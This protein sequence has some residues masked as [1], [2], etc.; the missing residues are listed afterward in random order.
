MIRLKPLLETQ[1]I[2]EALPYNMAKKYV[3]IERNPAIEARLSDILSKLAEQEGAKSS[4]RRDRVAI[5]FDHKFD[6]E[7]ELQQRTSNK[8][9]DFSNNLIDF[10]RDVNR[11]IKNQSDDNVKQ[12]PTLDG[13]EQVVLGQL[14]DQY[15]RAVKMSKYIKMLLAYKV[16]LK[17]DRISSISRI[18]P[19][20][21]ERG[22]TKEPD[23]QWTTL[24]TIKQAIKKDAQT[25][26]DKL[27]QEYD[28]IPEVKHYRQNKDKSY[29]LVFSKHSYDIAGMSTDR[30]WTSCMN[31]YGGMNNKYIQYD[32]QEGTLVVYLVSEDD[33]N[34]TN[35]SARISIKPFVNSN[36]SN[37]VYYQPEN[38]VYGTAPA[39]FEETVNNLIDSV[40][41]GKEGLFRLI[42][43]LYCDSTTQVVK[44]SD[45]DIAKKVNELISNKQQ[46]TTVDEAKYLLWKYY[47]FEFDLLEHFHYE[48][49]DKLYVSSVVN[50][51]H[52]PSKTGYS[53]VQI[54]KC[55]RFRITGPLEPDSYKTFPIEADMV[56][57]TDPL[58]GNFKGM[59]TLIHKNLSLEAYQTAAHITNF[60]GLQPGLS[61]VAIDF[62][63]D[64]ASSKIDSFHGI[65]AT[66]SHLI[67]FGSK[68]VNLNMTIDEL[69][70]QLKP[71]GLRNFRGLQL[72]NVLNKGLTTAPQSKL[73]NSI[74]KKLE[75]IPGHNPKIMNYD[76]PDPSSHVTSLNK[77]FRFLA[78][79]FSELPTLER[80]ELMDSMAWDRDDLSNEHY[81]PENWNK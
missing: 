37:D 58:Q 33:L 14:P 76:A 35:P 80:V 46:A 51:F 68:D 74:N 17:F 24:D 3:S 40:Q 53:P 29:Y 26:F 44:F 41:P 20:T 12:F 72:I 2:R 10:R 78:W 66:V 55:G 36:D 45:P 54:G 79:F 8:L 52:V 16:K 28:A 47:R 71:I 42:D 75:D 30:G 21:G 39:A 11:F 18:N 65:P 25:K 60:E 57:I 34:I 77:Q 13:P 64:S 63:S 15:G 6:I 56:G 9:I 19:D 31:L 49:S 69:I 27:M 62:R 73:F 67:I 81:Q 32:I 50:N 7:F 4:R 59:N 70:S 22:V 1:L 38:R 61:E 48:E 5:P 43:T 23:S